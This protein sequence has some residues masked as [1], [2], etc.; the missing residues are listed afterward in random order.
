MRACSGVPDHIQTPTLVR[1]VSRLSP[2][3]V[4][5]SSGVFQSLASVLRESFSTVVCQIDIGGTGICSS[6]IRSVLPVLS[7][8]STF[9]R[10]AAVFCVGLLLEFSHGGPRGSWF[11]MSSA[12]H[13][14][15]FE[16]YRL[17]LCRASVSDITPFSVSMRLAGL[18]GAYGIIGVSVSESCI[19][20]WNTCLNMQLAEH[21]VRAP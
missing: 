8:S 5:S 18:R 4:T 3:V 16:R 6:T 10:L 9:W 2:G 13:T 12:A 11:W 7:L 15:K 21:C 14:A 20:P 17:V 1:F 19:N